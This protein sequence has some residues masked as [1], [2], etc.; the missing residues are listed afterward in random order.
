MSDIGHHDIPANEKVLPI[1][2]EDVGD[3]GFTWFNTE[4]WYSLI[5][6]VSIQ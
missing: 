6:L 1:V 2:K 4:D 3:L 5:S